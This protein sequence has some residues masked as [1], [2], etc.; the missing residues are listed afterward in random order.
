MLDVLHLN[1]NRLHN[2]TYK[3]ESELQL[4]DKVDI[5]CLSEHWLDTKQITSVNIVNFRL[6]AH[7]CR[8]SRMGGGVCIY[9]S[10]E[11][12]TME[13]KEITNLSVEMQFEVCAIELIQ[14]N[15]SV[16]KSMPG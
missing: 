12:I 5:L 2:K 15:I 11:I 8:P 16:L 7:Y 1:I 6:R 10:P 9:A 4:R 3:L 13:R 14:L